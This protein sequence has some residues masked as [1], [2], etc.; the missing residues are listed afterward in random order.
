[1]ISEVSNVNREEFHY[2]STDRK[3]WL[4]GVAWV[5]GD[6]PRAILHI[7]HGVT[8]HI[9]RYDALATRLAGEG[10]LV[11]GV[12][13]IGHGTSEAKDQ[14]RLYFGPAGSWDYVVRDQK[15]LHDMTAEKYPGVPYCALGHSLGSFVVRSWLIRWPES[16][17]AAVLTG[18]GQQ[19]G[20][21]VRMG[22]AAAKGAA[23]REGEDQ[24]SQQVRALLF[25][26]YN[27]MFAPNRTPVDWLCANMAAVDSYLS[28]PLCSLDVTP[29]LFRELMSGMQFASKKANLQQMDK[30]CPVLFLSGKDDPVGELGKGVEKAAA[31]FRK[32]GMQDVTVHLYP[33]MRH[34]IFEET[35]SD[36]VVADLLEWLERIRN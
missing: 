13:L 25:G 3:T 28:D 5:P 32:A 33:G 19:S 34:N 10:Y 9:L 12:D 1:M 17:Q 2:M 20:L 31:A 26:N 4:H 8:E 24:P 18:T 22:L 36:T 27:R 30:T 6:S 14:A 21:S 15:L 29:G 11:L 23:R 35:G 16:L 7:V